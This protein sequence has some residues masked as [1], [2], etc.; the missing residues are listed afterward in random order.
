M[1][2][3]PLLAIAERTGPLCDI[4]QGTW[5]PGTPIQNSASGH[6][7]R[8]IAC[9]AAGGFTKECCSNG[10]GFVWQPE[11]CELPEFD[12]EWMANFTRGRPVL[13]AG[14]S[15]MRQMYLALVGLLS[16]S[17]DTIAGWNA[18][19]GGLYGGKSI[20]FL[21]HD[22]FVPFFRTNNMGK[23]SSRVFLD[24]A[25]FPK[26]FLNYTVVSNFLKKSKNSAVVVL[27]GWHHYAHHGNTYVGRNVTKTD[28]TTG[29]FLPKG[30]GG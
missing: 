29:F 27:G 19:V 24:H 21:R 16:Q 13:F 22:Y 25:H 28:G 9:Q 10:N 1:L 20:G 5:I 26:Q 18:L 15:L 30:E 6:R 23:L 2:V 3:L 11:S 8:G 17:K 7:R 12:S 14:D 4:T